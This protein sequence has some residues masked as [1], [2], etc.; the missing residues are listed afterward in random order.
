MLDEDVDAERA[1]ATY[2]RGILRVRL[3]VAPKR[4]PPDGVHIQVR[5]ER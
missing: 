4:P 5:I 2:E 3:P 1:Q